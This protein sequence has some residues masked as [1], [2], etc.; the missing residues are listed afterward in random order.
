MRYFYEPVEAEPEFG[1]IYHCDDELFD[2]GTLYLSD[3]IGLIVVQFQIDPVNKTFKFGP[4]DPG[5][6]NDIFKQ[7][8][9]R[10]FFL[11]FADKP[12]G[13]RR[14]PVM[15][16]RKVM[17]SLRMKPLRKDSWERELQALL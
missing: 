7:P 12:D 17:W 11:R 1:I 14:Y 3:N 8:G 10:E 5:L 15:N 2:L 13:A 4:I 6:A 9:F 16:V